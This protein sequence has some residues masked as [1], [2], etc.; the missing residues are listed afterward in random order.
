MCIYSSKKS[1]GKS[2]MFL[3]LFPRAPLLWVWERYFSQSIKYSQSN[4]HPLWVLPALEQREESCSSKSVETQGIN[5]GYG[6]GVAFWG[7]QEGHNHFQMTLDTKLAVHLSRGHPN[8][9]T[10][11]SSKTFRLTGIKKTWGRFYNE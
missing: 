3:W 2:I 9:C 1:L 6:G 4:P 11:S 7:P 5:Y 8:V 10:R